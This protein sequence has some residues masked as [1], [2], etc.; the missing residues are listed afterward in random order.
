MTS[1]L[2]DSDAWRLLQKH[3]SEIVGRHLNELFRDDPTRAERYRARVGELTL[4]YAKH[5]IDATTRQRLS[6]LAVAAGLDERIA[7]LF[8]GATVNAT[9][10]RP[11]LHMAL[12]GS[13]P[14]DLQVGGVSVAETVHEVQARIQRFVGQVRGGEWRGYTGKPIS[15]VVNIGI[16]GSE[17]G[18]RLAVEA[19]AP[20]GADGPRVHFLG[21]VDGAAAAALLRR[22]D[23]ETTLFCVTSKSFGTQETWVN[24]RTAR[25]WLAEAAGEAADSAVAAQFVAVSANTDAAGKFGIEADNVFPMWDWV[26]GRYSVWSAVGLPVA[27]A[28]GWQRFAEFLDGARSMDEHFRSAAVSE[29]LPVIVGLLAIWYRN[30]FGIGS[31]CV[32]A[33]DER[34]RA[35]PEYLQQL[36]MESNG[37]SATLDGDPVPCETGPVIWGGV[38]TNAQHAFFQALHQGTG[39]V[40]VDLIGVISP[41]HRLHEHHQA[42]LANLL[43]QGAALMRGKSATEVRAELAAAGK[44]PDEIEALVGH[45]T[46][47]GNRPSSTILLDRLTP[48]ALGTLLALYEHKVYVQASIW[49]IN[50][51]DQWGV[52]LGKQLAKQ[53]LPALEG[54]GAAVELDDSTAALAELCRSTREQQG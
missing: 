3:H 52:E 48:S 33:Y 39:M 49:G 45:R 10:H 20:Y 40:P 37:K 25:Q 13:T 31:H 6:Q 42:L 8:G 23:P 46:F 44:Q 4:D 1:P 28:V 18:P 29:N 11:A 12:R 27:V 53:V 43:G 41:H 9:E 21:N 5:R 36:E 22:L 17:L 19:L 54:T 26:G 38:G 50:A 14:A 16:G 2:T 35:L 34:L 51:F 7:A 47:P 24:A 15:D 30:F 32:V